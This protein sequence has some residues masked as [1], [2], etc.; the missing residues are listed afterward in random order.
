[1]MKTGGEFESA[2]PF[3]LLGPPSSLGFHPWPSVAAFE[4]WAHLSRRAPMIDAC[5]ESWLGRSGASVRAQNSPWPHSRSHAEL[6]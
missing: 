1:M 4:W 2:S 6:A 3:Q 5:E